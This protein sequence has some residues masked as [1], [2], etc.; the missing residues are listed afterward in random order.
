M[1]IEV[2]RNYLEIRS[3]RDLL[4]GQKPKSDCKVKI[5]EPINFKINKFFYKQVG[6]KYK[7][8]DRLTWDDKKWNEYLNNKNVKTYIL[9]K[10]DELI[11]YFE[12]IY[13]YS[14]CEI[15]YFGILEDYFGKNFGNYLL[16]E[17]IKISFNNGALRVWLHTCSLDHKNAL[18]NYVS[19]GMKIFKSEKVFIN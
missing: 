9:S 11:G 13:D 18:K 5:V 3:L 1:S 10:G 15:V 19:R 12:Q 2:Q 16:E 14:D 17:A 4:E 6:K 8:I 7:W